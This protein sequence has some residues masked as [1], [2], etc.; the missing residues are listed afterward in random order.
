MSFLPLINDRAIFLF[1]K[2]VTRKFTKDATAY[3]AAP[4]ERVSITTEH[5]QWLVTSCVF[6]R[7]SF[8]GH[9]R[10][11]FFHHACEYNRADTRR[12]G[13]PCCSPPWLEFRLNRVNRR[14]PGTMTIS[15]WTNRVAIQCR[16]WAP[17]TVNRPE[18]LNRRPPAPI[19][20]IFRGRSKSNARSGWASLDAPCYAMPVKCVNRRTNRRMCASWLTHSPKVAYKVPA[21][22]RRL[23]CL[24]GYLLTACLLSRELT[25]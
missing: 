20:R 21:S 4:K 5:R 23:W 18:R 10:T 24:H 1:Y 13:R 14:R 15:S 9:V 7:L 3:Y 17:V 11:L 19:R 25:N 2:F 6:P 8:H 22:L 12:R 16:L